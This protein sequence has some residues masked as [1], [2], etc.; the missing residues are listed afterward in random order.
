MPFQAASYESYDMVWLMYETPQV[1]RL[2]AKSLQGG[3]SP[4]ALSPGPFRRPS[5]HRR[6]GRFCRRIL[7]P[8]VG[9]SRPGT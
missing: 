7:M 3:P 8:T 6:C 4:C 9:H 2:S 5:Q 1:R